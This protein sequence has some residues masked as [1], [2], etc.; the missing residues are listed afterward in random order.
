MFLRRKR[1]Q[2]FS[3]AASVTSPRRPCLRFPYSTILSDT[4]NVLMN[5][6][7]LIEEET[8]PHYQ[9]DE[10]YPVKIGELLDSRYHV[11][12]KL[13]YGAS[14]TTWLCQDTSQKYFAVKAL[15]KAASGPARKTRE[16]DIYS[17]LSHIN[18]SHPGCTYIRGLYES[19]QQEG[20]H[21]THQCLV[22]PPMHISLRQLV[23]QSRSHRLN[24]VLL[25]RV[26]I[27]LFHALDYLH[28]EAGVIHT[29]IK[30]SNIM[31]SIDDST[32][33]SDFKAME[34]QY[35]SLRKVIAGNRFIYHSRRFRLPRADMWGFPILCDLGQARLGQKQQ[36]YIQPNIYKAPEVLFDMEW[37]HSVDIWNVGAMIWDIFEGK[38]L[39]S[40]LDEDKKYS[41]S[42]HAEMVAYLG[43]PSVEFVKRSQETKHVFDESG[44]WLGAGGVEIPDFSLEHA[45][46]NLGGKS[47]SLFLD[48]IRSMLQW[49]PEKRKSA[50]A[51]LEDPWLLETS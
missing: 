18:S 42:H 23:I 45:E 15:T 6:G 3:N 2:G 12:G 39:F 48:F 44:N 28:S 5:A 14:S 26:L 8:L 43:L 49:E 35:P 7:P 31:F 38:H 11:I 40:A 33:L 34:S 16:M 24:E 9:Q 10:F 41:P 30:S 21:G 25:K 50:R 47:K 29:D 4:R 32:I 17:H 13:G 19:F 51:L 46:Q 1:F 22:H 27:Y 20:P 37:S 36:G